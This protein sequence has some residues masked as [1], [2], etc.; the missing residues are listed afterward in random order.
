MHFVVILGAYINEL[1]YINL[2]KIFKCLIFGFIFEK[3]NYK[4][5]ARIIHLNLM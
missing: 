3:I 5:N 2:L 4:K 1:T